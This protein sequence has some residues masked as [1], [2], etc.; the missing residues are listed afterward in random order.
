MTE[1]LTKWSEA[2]AVKEPTAKNAA[3]FL[4][5]EIIHRFGVPLVLITNNGSHFKGEF[6]ELCTKMGIVHQ[7]GTPYHP[8]TTGQ[9]ERTNGLLLSQIRKWRT[10]QYNKWD[11]DLPASILAC[12]TRKIST[13]H[14]SPMECLMGFTANTASSVKYLRL[15]KPEIKKRINILKKEIPQEMIAN[16]LCVLDSLRDEAI[17][18]KDLNAQRMKARYD[19]KVKPTE[20]SVGE[21]VLL[22][23]A[24]L[25]KQWSRKLDE[26][27]L[28]PYVVAWK[29]TMGAYTIVKDGQSKLVTGDQLKRYYN[30]E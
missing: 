23:D 1:G 27:W 6:H 13:T 14:F 16:R 8:Q 19:K 21:E 2:K 4:M 28:G 22:F 26:R 30:R 10:E 24:T 5:D 29:G 20:F 7:C 11:D 15:S 17:K 18:V 12:N 25:L 9:D 3:K